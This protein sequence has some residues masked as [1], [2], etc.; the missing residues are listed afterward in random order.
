MTEAEWLACP[1]P[2]PMLEF[3][4]DRAP[5]PILRLFAAAC[6]RRIWPLLVDSRSRTAVEAVERLAKGKLSDEEWEAARGEAEAAFQAAITPAC[7]VA[8]APRTA[9][10]AAARAAF[11]TLL[12]DA[13]VAAASAAYQAA[14][15]TRRV[16]G[17]DFI[18]AFIRARH[19]QADML[20]A[21][22]G[23]PFETGQ[24]LPQNNPA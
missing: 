16:L 18:A 6:C 1:D 5:N 7:R 2:E 22:I 10:C 23:N 14:N 11:L 24:A 8:N 21:L 4:G 3:L 13:L 12:P 20:R 9:A 17:E 15:A 19:D